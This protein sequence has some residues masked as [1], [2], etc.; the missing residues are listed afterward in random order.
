M[1][2]TA[3]ASRELYNKLQNTRPPENAE[4]VALNFKLKPLG[5][6]VKN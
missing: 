5:V 1:T 3:F 2:C 6:C 4:F